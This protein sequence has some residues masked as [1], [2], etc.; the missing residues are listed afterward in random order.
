[1]R[2]NLSWTHCGLILLLTGSQL[3]QAIVPTGTADLALGK[4]ASHT[5]PT[6]GQP[7]SFAITLT[8]SG[9][10]HA[11]NV[12]VSDVLPAELEFISFSGDG[13]YDALGGFWNLPA[14]LAGTVSS[15]TINVQPT[16][17]GTRT[18]FASI[19]AS[20][21]SD[22]NA[23]NDTASVV[24]NV[25]GNPS[26]DLCISKT[27]S[28]TN[29][30]Q[31]QT[32]VFTLILENLG[33]DHITNEVVTTDCL[34]AGFQYVSDS[35][36]GVA[37]N[38]VYS[39]GT[40]WWTLPGLPA[41]ATATLYITNLAVSSGVFT[42]TASVAVPAGVTDL[43]L[44]NNTSSVV[45]T[46][47]PAPTDLQVTK[48][49]TTNTA[50]FF[51]GFN[52]TVTVTNLG[53][54]AVTNVVVVDKLPEGLADVYWVGYGG[55]NQN[56]T[57]S[58]GVWAIPVI[59][60]GEG[61]VLSIG[62]AGT[63]LGTFT[64]VAQL[65]N[66][67]PADANLANN[68]AAA[69]I[70][71]L[72]IEADLAVTK[73][74]DTNTL[75]FNSAAP[76][77]FF[78]TVTNL[79]PHTVSNLTLTDLLP[80]GLQFSSAIHPPGSAYERTNGIWTLANP[81]SAGQG[82]GMTLA[83]RGTNVGTFT[84]VLA[85]NL[86][87]GVVDPN[88]NNNSAQAVVM[89][90]PIELDL[91]TTKTVLDSNTLPIHSVSPPFNFRLTITNRG[92]G[93][94]PAFT[95][96]DLL[97]PGLAYH[98]SFEPG[99]SP[100][101]PSNGVW[102]IVSLGAGEGRRMTLGARGTNSGTFTNTATINI[103]IG[104]NDTNPANNSASAV[105]TVLPV[106]EI[107]GFV[108]NCS[109]NGLPLANV[110]VTLSGTANQVTTTLPGGFYKFTYV[111]NGNYTITPS[112]PGNVFVPASTGV[113]VNNTNVIVPPFV[114][115][116]G[117]IYGHVSYFGSPVTNHPVRL[118]G[119]QTR[120]VLTD[121]NGYYIFTNTPAGNF[122]VTPAVTNGFNFTPTNAALTL[123]ATNCAGEANFAAAGRPG[124]QL[125]A[126][127]VVQVIQDWSNSVRLIQGKETYV[128]THLQLTNNI[129]VLLQGARLHGTGP[130]G[131]LPGSPLSPIPPGTILIR[132]N[133]AAGM[134]TIFTN[135]LNFRLTDTWLTGAVSLRFECTN[136]VT[137]T[138][139]NVVPA[140]STVQVA[141]TPSRALP[142][143]IIPF[144]WR[145]ASDGVLQTNS[146]ANL[147][148]LPRRLLAMFPV[149]RVASTLAQPLV[150]PFTA[151]PVQNDYNA[152]NAQLA[153]L[154]QLAQF[155]I[156]ETRI[157]HGAVAR[158]GPERF[159]TGEAHTPGFISSALM[160]NNTDF[161][162]DNWLRHLASHEIGH[163][164][165]RQ[166][167]IDRN[168]FGTANGKAL[169]ACGED[170]PLAYAYPLFQPVPAPT[171]PILP[172]L[173]PMTN[174]VNNLIFGLD[175]LTL[176]T[177]R[178]HNPVANPNADFDVMGYCRN[179]P[180]QWWISSFTYHGMFQYLTNTF[181][182]PPAAP[183]AAPPRRWFFVRGPVDFPNN[184]GSFLPFYA[185]DTTSGYIPPAP[186]PGDYAIKLFDGLGNQLDEI[187]FAPTEDAGES[188]G[189][190]VATPSGSFI[191]P[192]LA[193]AYPAA[194]Q[195]VELWREAALLAL[196]A[197]SSNPPA[198]TTPL[199]VTETSNSF[200]LE[201][202]AVNAANYVIQFTPDGGATW[203]SLVMD[204]PEPQFAVDP[205]YL[206]ATTNGFFRIIASDGFDSAELI[207]TLPVTISNHAP[208]L[209]LNAPGGGDFFISDEQVFLDAS[210][211]DLEDGPLEGASIQWYSSLNGP[212]GAGS[213]LNFEATALTEGTH[214][215]TIQATDS[216]GLTS[217]ATVQIHVL[218]E[219]PPSLGIQLVGNQIQLIWPSSVTNYVLESTF[220]LVPGTWTIV[221]NMPTA[222]D[223][224]Q[225]VIL[226]TSE[227]NKFYRLRLP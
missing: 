61:F 134:R 25:V 31:G 187:P 128:R 152:L 120:W 196:R 172:A 95:V 201:W 107:S 146:A 55:I 122:I 2:W 14:A 108:K 78:L 112:H 32:V 137:V 129:P 93:T 141:F 1:M 5:T 164:L 90:K 11:T 35:T 113:I 16:S 145:K 91:V 60:P 226:E 30:T 206:A 224:E 81:L 162:V 170:G 159:A 87:T 213:V 62:S 58:N 111:S 158:G 220:S 28:A 133:N 165:G 198:F 199:F 148:D 153:G 185:M 208:G 168:I 195:R 215:I 114:G 123:D 77:N 76:F 99:D 7:F 130:G 150:A 109:S 8:N 82:I 136:N 88:T 71:I 44:M 70:M 160:P 89:V 191:I 57:P 149:A 83:A 115:S 193:N 132:T 79:G 192:I 80:P 169:G 67:V 216:L 41:N 19:T 207:S 17:A 194:I 139:T 102:S 202:S 63:A 177:A 26:S 157:Y 18:N 210:A 37:T 135:S 203:Q 125:V 184:T 49:V 174:G 21:I 54:N 27:A 10:D 101:Q 74:V 43:N 6:V 66:S 209:I 218:R 173:G 100:Y 204:W 212:L 200:L 190:G 183:P 23:A 106:Y 53:F 143:V 84:N 178:Q 51:E 166:H 38:G 4:S 142:I 20:T 186:A 175:T 69:K 171:G 119:A 104:V 118:T 40:C 189:T 121:G 156:T 86:P 94:V 24:V 179:A 22:T 42:N 161:Y 85:V 154:R 214:L 182:P 176:L 188:L 45:V 96:T 151:Q 197:A 73:Q 105:V 33:A 219:A 127:E 15:V 36:Y 9:P 72:P 116:V 29:V 223:A 126:L 52:F 75:P 50:R 68:S 211:S 167:D 144:N 92:P 3:T 34:P 124:V 39:P 13:N 97:P 225:S 205:E 147:A 48:T 140:N 64:N 12:F 217:S 131:P 65:T 227:S 46:V 47:I 222:A 163:N 103:P 181:V 98:S 56:Y 59:P 117:L 110:K 138:P 155:F 180:L 221:T